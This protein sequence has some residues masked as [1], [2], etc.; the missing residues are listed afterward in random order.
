[1]ADLNPSARQVFLDLADR[2]EREEPS[3]DLDGEIMFTLF[4]KPVGERG[5][6]WPED[7]AS[8]SFAMRFPGKDLAWFKSVRRLDT[9]KETILVWR[10]GDPILMN[11]LR[12]LKLTS[13]LDAAVTLVPEGAWRETNGPRRYLN[14]PTPVPN[15][16][17]C[18][19]SLWKPTYGDFHGWAATEAMAIC[20]ASLRARAEAL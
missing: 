16:W 7:N 9:D 10:D 11:A 2:C 3:R 1:M 8:W 5:Y 20:A 19:I 12:V 14:I 6:L 18:E 13:S 17:H 15:Y 4:A